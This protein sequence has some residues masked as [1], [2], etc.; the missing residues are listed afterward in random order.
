MCKTQARAQALCA[1]TL[2]RR[3]YAD[4]R[5]PSANAYI[6]LLN[7]HF[8]D[9]G[10]NADPNAPAVEYSSFDVLAFYSDF[11]D[12]V[13]LPKDIELN[14]RRNAKLAVWRQLVAGVTAIQNTE[15]AIGELELMMAEVVAFSLSCSLCSFFLGN[16]EAANHC[17]LIRLP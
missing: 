8:P 13:H 2:L 5:S 4:S 10:P 6:A 7:K 1:A 14:R 12:T 17:H 11:Y 3:R 16:E 15:R 9:P